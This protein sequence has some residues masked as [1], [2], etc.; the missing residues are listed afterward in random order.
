MEERKQY[1]NRISNLKKLEKSMQ[2]SLRE[3]Y[4]KEAEELEEKRIKAKADLLERE[5]NNASVVLSLLEEDDDLEDELF[6]QDSYRL[7]LGI[8]TPPSAP[9]ASRRR[10]QSAVTDADSFV[11]PQA[12]PA[13]HFEMHPQPMRSNKSIDTTNNNINKDDAVL[14]W[15]EDFFQ[16]GCELLS[17]AIPLCI[18][19][20]SSSA[21][22]DVTGIA[23]AG[24]ELQHTSSILT[25]GPTPHATN[26]STNI[27]NN[28]GHY[29]QLYQS[30]PMRQYQDPTLENNESGDGGDNGSALS[31]TA[32]SASGGAQVDFSTGLSGHTGISRGGTRRQPIRKK[33]VRMMMSVHD[34]IAHIRRQQKYHN[35]GGASIMS[36]SS[37]ASLTTL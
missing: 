17:C 23:A 19:P 13:Y 25:G 15:E 32:T 21:V 1:K 22:H 9:D 31:S 7:G 16:K 8:I 35:S 37:K 33:E 36:Q 11:N 10:R 4:I 20:T 14:T 3:F 2:T 28:R 27:N 5:K 6:T 30:P 34:G 18:G 12:P 29:Y 26:N 24:Q